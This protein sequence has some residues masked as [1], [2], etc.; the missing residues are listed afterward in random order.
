MKKAWRVIAIISM[1]ALLSLVA[2]SLQTREGAIVLVK[3]ALIFGA[4]VAFVMAISYGF[5]VWVRHLKN[6]PDKKLAALFYLSAAV[7]LLGL[8]LKFIHP[9]IGLVV[10]LLSAISAGTVSTEQKRREKGESNIAQEG[11]K[12]E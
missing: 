10:M 12:G 4:L 8:G 5:R 1:L 2:M 7:F 11:E 9:L 3:F 6:Q